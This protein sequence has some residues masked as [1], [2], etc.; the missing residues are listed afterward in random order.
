VELLEDEIKYLG[1]MLDRDLASEIRS[2]IAA[3][4]SSQKGL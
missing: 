1:K 4:E 3:V 2:E